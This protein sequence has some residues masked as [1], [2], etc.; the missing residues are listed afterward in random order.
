MAVQGAV[1]GGSYAIGN[2]QLAAGFMM[3]GATLAAVIYEL[4]AK[5]LLDRDV[6]LEIIDE[7]GTTLLPRQ[8]HDRLCEDGLG[9]PYVHMQAKPPR[10]RPF[11]RSRYLIRVVV[12]SF[13]ALDIALAVLHLAERAPVLS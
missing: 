3:A 11:M 13:F 7:L 9:E 10:R 2:H 8:I 4:V 12:L 5:D 1:V 6:N